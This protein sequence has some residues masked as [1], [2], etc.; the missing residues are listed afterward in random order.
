[1]T[2]LQDAYK[3]TNRQRYVDAFDKTL[4]YLESSGAKRLILEFSNGNLNVDEEGTWNPIK[5]A[6]ENKK[7]E[8][9]LELNQLK[10]SMDDL[11]KSVVV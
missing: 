4:E 8:F 10:Q 7:K 9:E 2:Y 11:I 1:M 3:N 5:N 6:Y